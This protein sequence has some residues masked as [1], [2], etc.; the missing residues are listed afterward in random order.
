MRIAANQEGFGL[1]DDGRSLLVGPGQLLVVERLNGIAL[2]FRVVARA[3][4]PIQSVEN[5]DGGPR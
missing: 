1:L 5:N 4:L 3:T 2:P